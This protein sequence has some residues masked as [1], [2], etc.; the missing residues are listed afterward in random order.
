[1]RDRLPNTTTDAG[2]PAPSDEY[3]L[4]AGPAG[5]NML[6]DAYLV[7]KLARFA[8]ERVPDRVYHVKGGGAFGHFEVTADVTQWTKA[9]FLSQVGKRTPMLVRFSTVAG[10]E[11][12]PDS[13]RDVRGFAMK[14]YTEEGNYDLVG[15]NTPVFFVRDPMKFPDFIHSQERLP[16]SGLRSNNMQWDFWT[17][18][19]ESAHQVTILMSDRG[20]PRTWRHMHGFSSDTYMWENA[21]G[22]KFWVKY[23]FKTEQGIQNMTDEEARAMRAEDLDCHRRDLR[24]AIDRGDH[25]AWRL[26]M[27]IM[28]FE[29]AAGYRFNPFDITK[30]WPHK[31]YPTIPVGRFVLDRNP[32]NFFAQIMQA[33][34]DVANMVPGIG[35]S[36]DR[37]VLGRMFAYGDSNRYRTGPNY[38]QLPVNRP[39]DEVHNYNKDG[40]MRYRHSGNQPVYAPNSYGGPSADPQRH[41]DPGW[42]V[43]A[44]DLMRTAYVAHKDDDDFVQPGTLYRQV[45]TPT[46]RDHLAGN[47]VWHLSQGVERFIQERAVRDYWAKVDTDLGARIAHDLGLAAPAR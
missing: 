33:G 21:A 38:E 17:L 26:E 36:P 32:E 47:I 35:P 1:M 37:M 15:N 12:Y 8:R 13:D 3:S 31:D 19:P 16:D 43:E 11:G 40:P 42:F 10:E 34:F 9:A 7:Q 18:S 22:E 6:H 30:V 39:L 45:M 4:T 44:A 27:Q 25:P 14:F 24:E 46:D 2:A 28:P 23:H 20:T 5:P 29:D 41:R